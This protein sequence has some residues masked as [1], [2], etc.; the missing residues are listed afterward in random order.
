VRPEYSSAHAYFSAQEAEGIERMQQSADLSLLNQG[1]TFTV[2]SDARGSEKIFP[3]D[4]MPRLINATEWA[5]IEAGIVQRVTAMNLFL[6]DI[7]HD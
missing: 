7:Y 4:L 1:V 2:Y 5:R 6:E 3:Y